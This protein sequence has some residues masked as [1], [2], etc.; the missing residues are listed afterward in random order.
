MTDSALYNSV[1]RPNS[2][3]TQT[4][5]PAPGEFSDSRI[6]KIIR[7][8]T[9]AAKPDGI[10]PSEISFITS[11]LAFK[12]IDHPVTFSHGTLATMIGCCD[13]KTIRRVEKTLKANGWISTT[14]RRG[15]SKLTS[16]NLD[17][18]PMANRTLPAKPS[19]A[20]IE[21]RKR[22]LQ[23]LFRLRIKFPHKKQLSTQDWSAQKIINRCDGNA[24]VAFQMIEHA[25]GHAKHTKAARR[26]LYA[27][28]QR[29]KAIEKTFTSQVFTEIDESMFVAQ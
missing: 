6:L 28:S 25:I 13:E 15:L 18:L 10:G 22:Y 14:S 4:L 5:T 16:V 27:L 26:G 21:L 29:W 24:E 20:A 19:E 12:A 9:Q 8:F 23:A 17:R 11:L 3:A 1:E 7:D 2:I